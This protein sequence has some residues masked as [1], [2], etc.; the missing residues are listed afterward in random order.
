MSLQVD[1]KDDDDGVERFIVV[2]IGDRREGIRGA[3]PQALA[4]DQHARCRSRQH[5]AYYRRHHV[6]VAAPYT[7]FPLDNTQYAHTSTTRHGNRHSVV[8]G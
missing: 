8:T 7:P 3:V 6:S 5:A 1:G 2:D 4:T